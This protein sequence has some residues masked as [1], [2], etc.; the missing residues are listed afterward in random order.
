MT[1]HVLYITNDIEKQRLAR[2][3]AAAPVIDAKG[4]KMLVTIVRAQKNRSLNQNATWH[5]WVSIMAELA[6][7]TFGEMKRAVKEE[8]C[9]RE[10]ITNPLTGEVSSVPRG[11]SGMSTV[12]FSELMTKTEILAKEQFDITLPAPNDAAAWAPY[13]HHRYAAKAA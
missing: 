5:G 11:T 2:K 3:L 12:E 13:E 10:E 9:P 8:L 1:R 4:R 6:G 7:S